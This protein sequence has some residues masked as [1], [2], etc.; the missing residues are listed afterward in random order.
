MVVSV[1]Y[2]LKSSERLTAQL[3]DAATWWHTA[4]ASPTDLPADGRPPV[5]LPTRPGPPES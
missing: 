4:T 1:P 2:Q 3:E 5:E